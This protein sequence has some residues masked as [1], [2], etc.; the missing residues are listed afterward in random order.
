MKRRRNLRAMTKDSAAEHGDA[1]SAKDEDKC[2]DG[3]SAS[4]ETPILMQENT[5]G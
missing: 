1:G 3:P 2:E 4:I 5:A